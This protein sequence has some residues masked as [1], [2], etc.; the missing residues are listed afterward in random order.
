MIFFCNP[1]VSGDA[2]LKAHYNETVQRA[3]AAKSPYIL[4]IQ[5]KT[6]LDF[7]THLSKTELGRIGGKGRKS[8]YGLFQH[9]TLL[10][11]ARNEPLGLIDIKHFDYDDYDPIN[12][13]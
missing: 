10:V 9:N 13:P 4:A 5:D 11:N 7:T 1:K 2:L 8:Q 3:K 12:A 6:V